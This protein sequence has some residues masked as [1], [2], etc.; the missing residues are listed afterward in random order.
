[1]PFANPLLT[2]A[3]KKGIKVIGELELAFSL[4]RGHLVAVTGTN[5][6]TTTVSLIGEML[7]RNGRQVLVGGNI[8]PG[9]PFSSIARE[10]TAEHW[11]VL[12]V[13]S[14]Q[15]ETIDRFRPAIAALLNLTPDHLDRYP[16]FAA[17]AAAKARVFLNQE[18]SDAAVLN[19]DDSRA[20]SCESMVRARLHHFSRRSEVSRGA[21]LDSD[22]SIVVIGGE[23]RFAVCHHREVRL[24]GPA[25]LEN[26]LAA[27]AV[28]FA[29]GSGATDIAD[30]LRNFSGVPHRLEEVAVLEGVRYV[31]NSMCTNPVAAARSLEA[32]NGGIVL[33]AGGKEKGMDMSPY[34]EAIRL[35]TK[36]A[37]L[38]GEN[39]AALDRELR[40]RGYG[41]VIVVTSLAEAV[42]RAAQQAVRGDVV[43]F[44]P[45]AASFDLFRD[46]EDRGDQFK[47]AVRRFI[48]GKP[49]GALNQ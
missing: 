5:G 8:A 32:F 46:F 23:V 36:A 41:P 47:A 27:S 21:F 34:L 12:E 39:A 18:P 4:A 42:A 40:S 14:F 38:L 49:N 15:L 13:S 20:R 43:L 10:A 3:R 22:G 29:A 44:S 6:K 45:G 9:R 16:D 33:I 48:S 25:N 19:L 1:V 2:Q 24:R 11:I 31:N 26:A 7:A 37:V 28:A 35:R 30:A 17:Y